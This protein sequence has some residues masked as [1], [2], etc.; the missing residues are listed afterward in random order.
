[1]SFEVPKIKYT[2]K[3]KGIAGLSAYLDRLSAASDKD[4]FYFSRILDFWNLK[5]HVK[6]PHA[7]CLRFSL[8]YHSLLYQYLTADVR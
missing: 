6:P 7:S 3:I 5:S 4:L 8:P 2:G 1:M